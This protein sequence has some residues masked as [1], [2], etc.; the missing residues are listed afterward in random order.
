MDGCEC[1][2]WGSWGCEGHRDTGLGEALD[3]PESPHNYTRQCLIEKPNQAMRQMAQE[4]V[5]SQGSEVVYFIDRVLPTSRKP[6][7]KPGLGFA[8]VPCTGLPDVQRASEWQSGGA[9]VERGLPARGEGARRGKPGGGAQAGRWARD[10]PRLRQ[11]WP[12]PH[13]PS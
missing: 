13:S 11:A 7:T 12:A 5:R 4:E 8:S 1:L 3:Y 10:P 2:S 6:P 9:D